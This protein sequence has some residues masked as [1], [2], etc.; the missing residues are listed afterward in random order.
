MVGL[1]C[2][3]WNLERKRPPRWTA[4]VPEMVWRVQIYRRR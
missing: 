1:G 4:P 2:A 3:G